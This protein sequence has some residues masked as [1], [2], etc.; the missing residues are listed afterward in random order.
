MKLNP[1][2]SGYGFLE[3]PRAD[4]DAVWFSELL[5]GGLHRVSPR[6]KVDDFLSHRQHIGGLAINHDGTIICSGLG[7]IVWF[8]PASGKTGTLLDSVDGKPLLGVNDMYPDGKGGLY[9]GTVSGAGMSGR[10]PQP[11]TL[12]HLATD[13]RVRLLEDGLKICNGIGL[14]PDGRRFYHNE[15]LVGTFVYDVLADGR[16]GNRR[17]FSAQQD[18]DGLAVDCEGGVWSAYFASGEIVRYR[19]DGSVDRHIPV[20]QKVVTSLCFGGADWRELYVTTGGNEGVDAMLNDRL[21]P[22]EATLYRARSDV[23]GLP[24]PRTRFHFP[25]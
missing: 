24:V 18:C 3:A 13:G 6:G 22:R 17:V 7:G 12:Y 16:I 9:F 4:G 10:I 14:S 25:L 20:P 2:A 5:S 23:A 1:L 11:T 19:A 8:D 15:S 21:P